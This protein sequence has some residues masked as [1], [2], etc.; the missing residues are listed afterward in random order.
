MPVPSTPEHPDPDR[1][2][3]TLLSA[4]ALGRRAERLNR[5]GFELPIGIDA[6]VLARRR[7]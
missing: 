4:I 7:R 3:R 5:C 1:F 2:R 6:A